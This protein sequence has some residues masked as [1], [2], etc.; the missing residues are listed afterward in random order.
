MKNLFLFAFVLLVDSASA[1]QQ[2]RDAAGIVTFQ[3]KPCTNGSTPAKRAPSATTQPSGPPIGSPEHLQGVADALERQ[4]EA[5]PPPSKKAPRNTDTAAPLKSESQKMAF[6]VCVAAANRVALQAG[7]SGRS[8]PRIANSS[9][10]YIR[11]VCT[12]DGSLLITCSRADESMITTTSPHG[13][14]SEGCL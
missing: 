3:D 10:L 4:L 9:T 8:S 11:R 13:S 5:R 7:L 12:D 2:C 1:I 6:E 14:R